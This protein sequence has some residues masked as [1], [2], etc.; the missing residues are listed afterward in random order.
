MLRRWGCRP[1][2]RVDP[3][4]QMLHLEQ[5][6]RLVAARAVEMGHDHVQPRPA[7]EDTGDEGDHVARLI[8]EIVAFA[9]RERDSIASTSSFDRVLTLVCCTRRFPQLG[10]AWHA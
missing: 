7:D 5:A 10:G 4:E 2:A 8:V 9:H 3:L 6:E 1:V